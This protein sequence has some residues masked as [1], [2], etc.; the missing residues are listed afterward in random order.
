MVGTVQEI[1]RTIDLSVTQTELGGLAALRHGESNLQCRTPSVQYLH[2]HLNSADYPFSL[3]TGSCF[4]CFI[5]SSQ[6]VLYLVVR[7]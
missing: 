5:P 4:I 3:T 2:T 1:R 7:S 6:D